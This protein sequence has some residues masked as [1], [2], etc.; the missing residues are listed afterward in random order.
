MDSPYSHC[1]KDLDVFQDELSKDASVYE[2]QK[3]AQEIFRLEREPSSDEE[4]HPVF[5]QAGGWT[6][7]L[8][9]GASPVLEAS[10]GT[11]MFPDVY[12][13]EGTASV[14]ILLPEETAPDPFVQEEF[15]NLGKVGKALLK[16]AEL[17]S[18]GIEKGA[19]KASLLI[20][21]Y[22]EKQTGNLSVQDTENSG[23]VNPALKVTAKGAKLASTATVKVSGFVANR[24][25]KLSKKL[26]SHLAK[27]AT[28]SSITQHGSDRLLA[29]GTVYNTLEE[30]AKVLGS[31]LQTNSVKV[32]QSKYGTESADVFNDSMTAAGNA[33]M[34]YMNVQSLGV[35]GLVKK[36]AKETG[37][38]IG[39]KCGPWTE[40]EDDD[41]LFRGGLLEALSLFEVLFVGE[42]SFFL[43]LPLQSQLLLQNTI[44]SKSS[45]KLLS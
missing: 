24:V 31:S 15:A 45:L 38:E 21:N 41:T 29:Y 5:I 34:T 9:P 18:K 25:S 20:D 26:A 33:A 32:V 19:E 13:Q 30:S 37:K 36:T 22:G 6:H 16:S 42:R 39:E 1:M 14:G 28:P 2:P 10:N 23:K 11:L 12:A 27:Q 17:L 7:P 44:P 8:I 3:P 40:D 43:S 4:W 35:K